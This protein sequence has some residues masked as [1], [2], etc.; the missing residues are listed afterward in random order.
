MRSPCIKWRTW[1]WEPVVDITLPAGYYLYRNKQGGTLDL[2][3]GNEEWIGWFEPMASERT[4]LL[5]VDDH[6][7][8]RLERHDDLC[9]RLGVVW[10]T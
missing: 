9:A 5:K 10:E 6:L 2:V 4:I 7:Y 8:K 1:P 3:Y